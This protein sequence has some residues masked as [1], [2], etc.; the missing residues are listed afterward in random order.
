M[1]VVGYFSRNVLIYTITKC[2]SCIIENMEQHRKA[3]LVIY[4]VNT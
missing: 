3:N 2:P 4:P 1:Y